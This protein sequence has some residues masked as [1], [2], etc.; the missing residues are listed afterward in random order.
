MRISVDVGP[1]H[2]VTVE[3]DGLRAERHTT[4]VV[5]QRDDRPQRVRRA[6][7]VGDDIADAERPPLLGGAGFRSHAVQQCA[8]SGRHHADIATGSSSASS[9]S[10]GEQ[11]L[12]I[13]TVA[14]S[15]PRVRPRLMIAI[16]MPSAAAW[17][18]N[19]NPGEHRQRRAGHQQR[20]GVVDQRIRLRH[21]VFRHALA[22]VDDVGLEHARAGRAVDDRERRGVA[23]DGVCVGGH[24]DAAD[25]LGAFDEA[26]GWPPRAVPPARRGSSCGRSPGRS[27]RRRCR[28]G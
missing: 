2:V 28:A 12:S 1:I 8:W 20:V 18:T 22:E 7:H 19:R 27:P 10:M 4:E 3:L 5:E 16:G 6:H 14:R 24:R 23:D 11:P 21:T 15:S 26:R 25:R 13:F 9:A 17:R